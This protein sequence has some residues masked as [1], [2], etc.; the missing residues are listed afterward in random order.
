MTVDTSSSDL[1]LARA[2]QGGSREAYA[3]LV[4]RHYLPIHRFLLSLLDNRTDAEDLTQDTFLRALDKIHRYNPKLPF[5]PWVFTIARRLAISHWR[6]RR[7]TTELDE[8]TPDPAAHLT[9][10][11]HDAAALWA[12]ARRHLK[13][14]EFSA[15]WCFYREDMPV[16]ELAKVLGKTVTHTKVILHR[17]RTHLR[18]HLEP[19]TWQPA[20]LTQPATQATP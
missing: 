9:G 7:P 1:D 8:S 17:A 13:P 6:R 19:D 14:D 4:Q 3:E 5:R 16:K 15:L 18:P 11:R 12:L 10:S 2:A 20:P